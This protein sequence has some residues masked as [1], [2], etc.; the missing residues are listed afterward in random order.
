MGYFFTLI[1][2][3]F[4]IHL[5]WKESKH[6]T[7]GLLTDT[8]NRI[9]RCFSPFS[10][11]STLQVEKQRGDDLVHVLRVPDVGL[12]LIIDSLPHNTLQALDTC[13]ADPAGNRHPKIIQLISESING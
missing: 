9:S 4:D 6:K 3:D 13:H 12:Q 11:L 8:E 10:T 2:R 7:M 1:Q 5:T